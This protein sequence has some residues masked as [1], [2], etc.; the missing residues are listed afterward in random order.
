MGK[1]MGIVIFEEVQEFHSSTI[2]GET[3][4]VPEDGTHVNQSIE[5]GRTCSNQIVPI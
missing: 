1:L 2:F 4:V 3:F 5:K